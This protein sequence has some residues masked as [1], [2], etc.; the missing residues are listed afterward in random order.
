VKPSRKKPGK[1]AALK[2]GACAAA[3]L[4]SEPAEQP[5]DPL[6][7]EF[8]NAWKEDYHWKTEQAVEFAQFLYGRRINPRLRNW[9]I[10]GALEKCL[11]E[12]G[13]T[14]NPAPFVKFFETLGD[15]L[16]FSDLG[17]AC[18][19]HLRREWKGPLTKQQYR[20]FVTL[21]ARRLGFKP[22]DRDLRKMEIDIGLGNALPSHPHKYTKSGYSEAQG[23]MDACWKDWLA[24]Q[25]A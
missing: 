21:K 5:D 19:L 3:S 11:A 10:R 25:P 7:Q 22:S 23:R 8:L 14:G 16:Q 12:A 18:Y 13:K 9:E 24:R 15:R 20:E 17:R 2:R 4:D 6:P 1:L